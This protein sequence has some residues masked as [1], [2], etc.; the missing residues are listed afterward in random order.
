MVR[1]FFSDKE[2]EVINRFYPT[3][4][5]DVVLEE[6]A[7]VSPTG[8]PRW[9]W[10]QVTDR[11]HRQGVRRDQAAVLI[12]QSLA[13]NASDSA[14]AEQVLP[15]PALIE[16][17]QDRGYIILPQTQVVDKIIKVDKKRFK[18]NEYEFGVV[19]DTHY[20]SKYQQRTHLQTTYRYFEDR[21]IKDIYH[22]G[23]M[24]DGQGMYR[25]HEYEIFLHGADA[26]RDYII[27]YYPRYDG[28]TTYIIGGSHDESHWKRSGTNI[29]EQIGEK[30]P[31]IE[32]K[33]FHG[34]EIKIGP[35]RAYLMHGSGGVSYARSYKLQKI[36]EQFTPENKPEILLLGH[37]HVVCHLHAYRNVEGFLLPCF[38][39]QTPYL[40]AKGL[41]PIIGA[42]IIKVVLNDI[43][44]KDGLVKILPEYLPFYV[45]KEKD[46]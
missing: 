1:Q 13:E 39:A 24:S 9:I 29:L 10:R 15:T 12:A 7:K 36:I 21:G 44:R 46:W 40:K 16:T 11:A 5:P 8:K 45:P 35:L 26:Q 31:D 14:R 34:A 43:D 41:A 22:A 30:R 19:S 33:G 27:E 32:Y 18:G 38:Q 6:L 28:C 17:L 20:C 25:G 2:K 23:D 3:A 4:A 37:Y 42:M